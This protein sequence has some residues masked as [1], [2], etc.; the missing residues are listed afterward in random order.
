LAF[1]VLPLLPYFPQAQGSAT[2]LR[3]WLLTLSLLSAAN[4]RKLL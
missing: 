4:V 3:L 2:Y 1:R